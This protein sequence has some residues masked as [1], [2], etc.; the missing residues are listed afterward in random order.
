VSGTDPA[1]VDPT[2]V[3]PKVPQGAAASRRRWLL[4]A[5]AAVVIL[6]AATVSALVPRPL[7]GC[8]PPPPPDEVVG[9]V[10]AVDARSLTDVRGFTL[11]TTVGDTLEFKL[12]R[13]LQNPTAF[14]PGHL[15]E[16]QATSS[17]VRVL[18]RLENGDRVVYRLEDAAPSPAPSSVPS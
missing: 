18:Y 6:G 12:T 17:P 11:R 1:G 10:V 13:P 16:H 14:P 2:A 4:P 15:A 9:I 8:S 7:C 5:L 3:P